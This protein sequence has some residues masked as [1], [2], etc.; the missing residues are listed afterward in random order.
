MNHHI[1]LLLK[2]GK[3]KTNIWDFGVSFALT[4]YCVDFIDYEECD[5]DVNNISKLNKVICF[6]TT[7]PKFIATNGDLLNVFALFLPSSSADIHRF[8]SQAN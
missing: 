3:S 1:H 7:L 2:A 4:P 8:S 6:G 5:I